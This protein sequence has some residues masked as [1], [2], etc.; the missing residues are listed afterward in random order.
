MDAAVYA[1]VFLDKKDKKKKWLTFSSRCSI[2]VV[3][4]RAFKALSKL[5]EEWDSPD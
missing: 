3:L 2:E 1:G 5:K 4:E